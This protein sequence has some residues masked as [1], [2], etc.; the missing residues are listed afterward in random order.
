M[1]Y[2]PIHLVHQEIQTSVVDQGGGGACLDTEYLNLDG[3]VKEDV[4]EYYVVENRRVCEGL[5]QEEWPADTVS[6][7]CRDGLRAW[8]SP[9]VTQPIDTG[10]D[11]YMGGLNKVV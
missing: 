7:C 6:L 1:E 3:Q 8:I 11:G 5:L 9:Q 10:M 2:V 4:A